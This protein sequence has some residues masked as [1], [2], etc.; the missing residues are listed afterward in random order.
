M[1]L[2]G[3]PLD[4]G[5]GIVRFVLGGARA[6]ATFKYSLDNGNTW[7]NEIVTAATY[8]IPGSGLTLNFATGTYVADD[9]YTWTST[10]PGYTLT[11][12]DDAATALRRTGKRFKAIF[13]VGRATGADDATKQSNARTMFEGVSG[14][15]D[16]FDAAH[17]STHAFV[18]S[19]DTSVSAFAAEWI[20]FAD[21]RISICFGTF[22]CTSA[23]TRRKLARSCLYAVAPR[24]AKTE[25]SRDLAEIENGGA[26]PAY[27][28][29]LHHDEYLDGGANEARAITLR[30]WPDRAGKFISNPNTMA[31]EG[32]DFELVQACFVMNELDAIVY[33]DLAT[34]ASKRLLVDP[35]TGFINEGEAKG[36][37]SRLQTKAEGK[38]GKHV[39]SLKVTITRDNDILTDKEV[40][41]SNEAVPFAYPKTCRATS[42]YV[43]PATVA[44]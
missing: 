2:T 13:I 16:D 38:L 23:I 14:I 19:P 32:S 37:E 27:V 44:A 3:T 39:S 22:D 15:L 8:A 34:V 7:S 21:R 5:K 18:E 10:A 42:R 41:Y 6:V 36:L 35:T 17:L 12:L 9:E 11:N 33:S 1:T 25:I 24:A 4:D 40:L 43:N 31:A 28:G 29:D 30:T 20:D 26:L